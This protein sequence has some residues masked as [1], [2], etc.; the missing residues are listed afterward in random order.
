MQI[1]PP[2]L[3]PYDKERYVNDLSYRLLID[4]ENQGER[5]QRLLHLLKLAPYPN[6]NIQSHSTAQAS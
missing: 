2:E 5:H 4:L 1:Q 3:M 6:D